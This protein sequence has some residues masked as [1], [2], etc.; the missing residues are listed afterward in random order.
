MRKKF[1]GKAGECNNDCQATKTQ[2]MAEI[3]RVQDD[4]DRKMGSAIEK[5]EMESKFLTKFK[6]EVYLADEIYKSYTDKSKGRQA[7]L[8]EIEQRQSELKQHI[9]DNG[10]FS[11]EEKNTLIQSTYKGMEQYK[12][13]IKTSREDIEKSTNEGDCMKNN[14]DWKGALCSAKPSPSLSDPVKKA[15]K[16]EA[17]SSLRKEL[18]VELDNVDKMFKS[19]ESGDVESSMNE[20]DCTKKQGNW[21]NGRCSRDQAMTA[22]AIENTRSKLKQDIQNKQILDVAERRRLEEQVDIEVNLYTNHALINNDVKAA[23]GS[24]TNEASCQSAKGSWNG[25]SCTSL[26]LPNRSKTLCDR[27]EGTCSWSTKSQAS[28]SKGKG[29]S[30]DIVIE[31]T[32]MKITRLDNKGSNL[33]AK[34]K[35]MGRQFDRA[36][37]FVKSSSKKVV[38]KV[39]S[40]IGTIGSAVGTFMSSGSSAREVNLKNYFQFLYI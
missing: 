5:T 9:M 37:K 27:S 14:G 18:D 7:A 22:A 38:G 11:N 2:V 26:P 20:G 36:K 25:A 30:S 31:S 39:G 19:Y 4:T 8:D 1:L 23:I 3:S 10:Q 29:S 32:N 24:S 12:E 15:I 35:S 16:T 28:S 34:K 21:N 33:K 17:E 6:E 40:A 13:H